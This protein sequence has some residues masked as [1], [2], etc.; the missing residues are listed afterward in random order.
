MVDFII[1]F[2]LFVL[3]II[4]IF[5]FLYGCWNIFNS[6]VVVLSLGAKK[7]TPEY[8][9]ITEKTILGKYDISCPK[10][11]CL[12]CKHV[13]ST[14]KNTDNHSIFQSTQRHISQN[15][16]RIFYEKIKN[17]FEEFLDVEYYKCCNC[18]YVF[19]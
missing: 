4:L 1:I 9:G 3:F 17:I 15:R 12:Y 6:H 2:S 7:H 10:C 11:H 16:L 8:P 13:Y 14:R 18:G 19:D 5:I